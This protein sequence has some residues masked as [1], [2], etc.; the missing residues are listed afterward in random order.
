MFDTTFSVRIDSNS[1]NNPALNLTGD[2]SFEIT[3]VATDLAGNPGDYQLDL[4]ALGVA[5]PDTS[6]SIGG[7]LYSFDVE[8]I[9]TLPTTQSNGAQQVPDQF[10]GFRVIVL[11]LNDYPTAGESLRIAFMPDGNATTADMDA[12]GNGA[13]DIQGLGTT[14][15]PTYI[16]FA[17]DT[18]IET[19]NGQVRVDDLGVGDLVMTRDSGPQPIVWAGHSTLNWPDADDRMKPIKIN[20]DAF[21]PGLPL[22]DLIVS[23]QHHMFISNPHCAA[24]FAHPEVLAPA[25]GLTGMAGIRR[26]AGKKSVTYFHILLEKHGVITAEGMPSESFYPGPNA[27][28]MMQP[29]QRNSLYDVVPALR[30]RPVDGYGDPAR[31]KITRRQAETLVDRMQGRVAEQAA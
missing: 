20:A 5:D 26:M 14:P 3:F 23:P 19:P 1:A 31:H 4:P 27:V 8:Y 21:G 29:S 15:P 13:I 18:L 12:F 9:G 16:C 30:D 11:T 25:K 22:R 28:R 6:I 24:L 17:S 10:E 7:Q 2:P